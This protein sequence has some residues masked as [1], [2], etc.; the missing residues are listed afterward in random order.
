MISG[1]KIIEFNDIEERLS[2]YHKYGAKAGVFVGF[3]AFRG[4]YSMK[5]DG[6][7]DWTGY[8][9][10]GKTELLLEFLFNTSTFYGWKHLLLVPDIG[11]CI[12]VMAILIHK[13][14]GKTFDKR[15]D[16]R[17]DIRTAFNA[18][19]WLFEHFFILEKTDPFSLVTPVEYWNFAVEFK[20]SKGIQ[21]ATI[22]SW[23]DLHHDY[24]KHG[25]WAPYLSHVLPIRNTLSEQHDIHFHTVIH[26]KTPRRNKNGQLIHPQIDDMEGGAQWGNSGKTIISVHRDS[27]TTKIADIQ[28]L[29]VKPRVV[30]KRG[31]P[32]AINFDVVKSRYFEI[33]GANGGSNRYA[34]R[35]GEAADLFTPESNSIIAEGLF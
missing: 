30:G 34:H 7:T 3:E 22:D 12:E 17:I 16:N 13:Y 9:Q 2:D 35:D 21:T 4:K 32:F 11:D 20:K 33:D 25:G 23:K 28:M 31:D 26:P 19:A 29:K 18:C 14:T 15:Y 8:P 10:S 5:T 27:A 6:V 1:Y 24:F